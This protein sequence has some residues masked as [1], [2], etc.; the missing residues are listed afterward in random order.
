MEK[1]KAT[2]CT[3]WPVWRIATSKGGDIIDGQYKI[4][5]KNKIK[6]LFLHFKWVYAFQRIAGWVIRSC[7][8]AI[9]LMSSSHL[10]ECNNPFSTL[11]G[12][13][14]VSFGKGGTNRVPPPLTRAIVERS[15]LDAEHFCRQLYNIIL[16]RAG[17]VKQSKKK[18]KNN[19]QLGFG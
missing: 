3:A 5:Y 2:K 12:L 1:K 13:R 15:Q 8:D 10:T 18:T 16:Y 17:E 6:N 19:T 14:K 11:N 4:K 7:S 9:I